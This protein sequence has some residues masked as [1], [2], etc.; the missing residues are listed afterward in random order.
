MW[1]CGSSGL[2]KALAVSLSDCP[3]PRPLPRSG[4]PYIL[5]PR[6]TSGMSLVTPPKNLCKFT[7][8]KCFLYIIYINFLST[9]SLPPPNMCNWFKRRGLLK[10][11]MKLMSP[12]CGDWRWDHTSAPGCSMTPMWQEARSGWSDTPKFWFPTSK[13]TTSTLLSLLAVSRPWKN[14]W[15]MIKI[16]QPFSEL[17]VLSSVKA[18]SNKWQGKVTSEN[19]WHKLREWD[20]PFYPIHV[21]FYVISI[22]SL[23]ISEDTIR[24]PMESPPLELWWS[25]TSLPSLN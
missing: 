9:S 15:A 17:G 18:S 4:N 10:I 8:D 3:A 16:P 25:L 2:F 6:N 7:P 13:G 23:S 5:R 12:V 20:L 19:R 1:V 21:N 24:V 22:S 11:G 14:T